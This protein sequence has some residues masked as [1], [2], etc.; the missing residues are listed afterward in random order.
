LSGAHVV[1]IV[2]FRVAIGG[3]CRIL[4]ADGVSCPFSTSRVMSAGGFSTVFGEVCI[5]ACVSVLRYECLRI[6]I[7][8]IG[9]GVPASNDV[10]ALACPWC[11]WYA[12]YLKGARLGYAL[13]CVH[14]C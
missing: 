1:G 14:G 6:G 5:V 12:D 8:D 11:A 7:L 4:L 2:V 3:R 10:V 9:L 13:G